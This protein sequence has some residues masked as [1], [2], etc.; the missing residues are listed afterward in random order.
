[1]TESVPDWG[2]TD[3]VV[4]LTAA[5]LFGL[6]FTG[7]GYVL[8]RALLAGAR[9]YSGAYSEEVARQFADLFLFIPARR[10][11][12]VA[13]AMAATLFVVVFL[14]IGGDFRSLPAVLAGLLVG[15]LAG[16]GGLCAPSVLLA[17]LKRRRLRR[18]NVQLVDALVAMSNAL[19]AGF[20]I[21]QAFETVV[22][23]GENPIAQEFDL[24]LQQTRMGISVSDALRN[25]DERVGSEDMTLVAL[26]IETARKTGGNLTEIFEKIAAMIRERMRIE[27]RI[28]TL[29]AQ[30][31]LQGFIL[32]AMPVV[33]AVVLVF[34]DRPTMVPFLHSPLGIGI[35]ATVILLVTLGA[36]AIR[37]IINIDV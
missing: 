11:R 7:L 35:C 36:L 33:I 30:G 6:C 15:G 16:L 2:T 24:F 14:P 3:T 10:V 22:K 20:S 4:G 23:E 29:T 25:L 31:R 21:L 28:R 17:Y 34:L 32:G 12:E 1:M 19:K 8:F 13:W 26:S 5:L 37:K 18:F 27:S 9:A